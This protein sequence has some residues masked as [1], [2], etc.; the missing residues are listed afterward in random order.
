MNITK[1]KTSI[2]HKI[3]QNGSL[4]ISNLNIKGILDL[5][6]FDKI[7]ELDCSNNKITEIINI[8]WSLAKLNCSNNNIK[9][10]LNLPD[11]LKTLNCKKNNLE[12]LHYPINIK[13]SKYPS[14]LK[15]ILLGYGFN[16]PIDNLP[17]TL[18]VLKLGKFQSTN[19]QF[20]KNINSIKIG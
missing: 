8:P 7:K 5:E 20:T 18:T 19:R 14:N 10:L 9:S 16:Q 12:K 11:S 6:D 2:I 17:N 13:P 4:N 1:I 3:E 15:E